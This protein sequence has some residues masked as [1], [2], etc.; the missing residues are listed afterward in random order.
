MTTHTE[1]TNPGQ[2]DSQHQIVS[3]TID[4]TEKGNALDDVGITEA[5]PTQPGAE[6]TEALQRKD[7]QPEWVQQA[8]EIVV[9]IKNDLKSLRDNRAFV[10]AIGDKLIKAKNLGAQKPYEYIV[11]ASGLKSTSNADN[12]VRAANAPYLRDKSFQDHLPVTVGA[13][14]DLVKWS[15]DELKACI[16]AGVMHPD[17]TR[18]ELSSWVSEYRGDE[19]ERK[20]KPVLMVYSAKTSW[21]DEDQK[22]LENLLGAMVG[23]GVIKIV[24]PL[25]DR[26]KYT[27]AMGGWLKRVNSHLVKSVRKLIS[28][29]RKTKKDKKWNKEWKAELDLQPDA[30]EQVI[31]YALDLIGQEDRYEQL[32]DEALAAVE[33]P[34][35][36]K[37][38]LDKASD[39]NEEE[40]YEQT[41][42]KLV[43][44]E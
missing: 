21:T 42:H 43:G 26:E 24:R 40:D 29:Y 12:Y 27:N 32:R 41:Y 17:A 35:P 11:A 44:G 8:N 34:D 14:I 33:Q 25:S 2:S 39:H 4:Y 5:P 19:T 28:V 16:A 3:K 31:R 36:A 7:Q 6:E 22:E 15:K 38:G 9:G 18:R 20:A 37:W 10:F 1:T 23:A 13:L 30:D